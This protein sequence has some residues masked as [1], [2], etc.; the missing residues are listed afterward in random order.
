MINV[1]KYINL[2]NED[3]TS[4]IT[5]NKDMLIANRARFALTSNTS[6]TSY[7]PLYIEHFFPGRAHDKEISISVE[8]ESIT[9]ILFEEFNIKDINKYFNDRRYSRDDDDNYDF[10]ATIL[11]DNCNQK[12]LEN[13]NTITY[14]TYCTC[15]KVLRGDTI[16][17]LGDNYIDQ[18]NDVRYIFFSIT[19]DGRYNQ[20]TFSESIN[21]TII[22]S[23]KDKQS[24]DVIIKL[25]SHAAKDSW[26]SEFGIK[27]PNINYYC[28]PINGMILTDYSLSISDIDIDIEAHI[29][30]FNM[31]FEIK[32][33][34]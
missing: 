31:W 29:I 18:L 20:V 22:V 2:E 30:M 8:F 14:K 26:F 12:I 27:A 33:K 24:N 17:L 28:I 15:K 25:T 3:Y 23:G 6:N 1:I 4:R 10:S 19:K 11:V 5:I 13:N 21:F 32:K 16:L 34:N 7:I 9:S